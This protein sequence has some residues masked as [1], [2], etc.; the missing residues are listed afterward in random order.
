MPRTIQISLPS[1]DF[2]EPCDE[3]APLETI[4]GVSLSRGISIKPPGDVVTIEVLNKGADDVLKI[5]RAAS[6]KHEISVTTS[7]AA[8]RNAR[9]LRRAR[10]GAE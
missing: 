5:V 7:E 6:E 9:L 10:N 4:L 3:L 2:Q 1:S 8:T